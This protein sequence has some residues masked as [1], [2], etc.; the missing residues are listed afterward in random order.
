MSLGLRGTCDLVLIPIAT[1]GCE[2][3]LQEE[4]LRGVGA[5]EAVTISEG[6]EATMLVE[7]ESRGNE[8]GAGKCLSIPGRDGGEGEE[9]REAF[10][11][12]VAAC[13]KTIPPVSQPCSCY[14]C[15]P[16]A[17]LA[18]DVLARKKALRGLHEV[19]MVESGRGRE[20]RRQRRDRAGNGGADE[21]F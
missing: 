1:E 4:I 7:G 13:T 3:S 14:H 17:P 5:R 12:D 9:G 8:R 10:V 11:W 21:P 16:S 15:R 19:A 6:A 18:G 20:G 2:E